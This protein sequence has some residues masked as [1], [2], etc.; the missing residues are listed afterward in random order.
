MLT[1]TVHGVSSRTTLVLACAA[2]LAV[3][4]P[5][6]AQTRLLTNQQ[7]AM[8]AN[9]RSY[10]RD[11]NGRLVATDRQFV[12][13]IRDNWPGDNKTVD[14]VFQQCYGGGFVARFE[15]DAGAGPAA[16]RI[17]NF[18]ASSAAKH[19]Q[20][21]ANVVNFTG[22]PNPMPG[23]PA[24][25]P[26]TFR[27]VDNFS[28]AWS[29]DARRNSFT[30]T[31]PNGRVIQIGGNFRY[32]GT[33]ANGRV[34]LADIGTVTVRRPAVASNPQYYSP[35][36]Q[37]RGSEGPNNG[38]LW[39]HTPEDPVFA[40]LVAWDTYNDAIVENPGAGIDPR[41]EARFAGN[42]T[43]MY[44]TLRDRFDVPVSNIVVLYKSQARGTFTPAFTSLLPNDHDGAA[45]DLRSFV[46]EAN[47]NGRGV[48][49]DGANDRA[50]WLQAIRGGLFV[51]ARTTGARLFIYST[52][53]GGTGEIAGI[54]RRFGNVG[55]L[56][57]E[58]RPGAVDKSLP[59]VGPSDDEGNF[60]VAIAGGS[61]EVDLQITTSRPLA[62]GARVRIDGSL[63]HA[64][65]I[66]VPEG[67]ERDLGEFLPLEGDIEPRFHYRVTFAGEMFDPTNPAVDVEILGAGDAD[68]EN[69]L[70]RAMVFT[71]GEAEYLSTVARALCAVDFNADG[72]VDPDDL[73]DFIAGMFAVPQD[74]RC[75]LDLD[76]LVTP[77]DLSD[78]ITAYFAGC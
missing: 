14:A 21:A 16:R 7:G 37:N 10:V 25:P 69:T 49:V 27:G 31:A 54:K 15:A 65:L 28:R 39:T 35:D 63:V 33:G 61:G 70:V 18:T 72:R 48:Y 74:P 9:Q 20:A 2:G 45:F 62:P 55:A 75:D 17:Q 76:G 3:A 6:V 64:S 78:Y 13:D 44:R 8:G 26:F 42:L 77:D 71:T 41:G 46:N 60:E 58:T 50:T 23:G 66:E 19:D 43:R 4:A 1:A 52:G 59:V 67:S 47:P 30:L 56:A 22:T 29:E 38:R 53:H 34:G 32:S 36:P 24:L 51:P 57:Y 68:A 5:V 40:I 12:Q 73:S 11:A